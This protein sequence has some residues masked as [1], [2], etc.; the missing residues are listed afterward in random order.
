MPTSHLHCDSGFLDGVGNLGDRIKTTYI[1]TGATLGAFVQLDFVKGL[2]LTYNGIIRTGLYT[3]ATAGALLFIN[4]VAEKGFTDT[5]RTVFLV[6]MGF[7][8]I[9]EMTYRTQYGIGK[10]L[11]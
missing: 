2:L 9:P 6:D 4:V 8:F 11:A 10:T 5:G 3:R 1:V 7:L